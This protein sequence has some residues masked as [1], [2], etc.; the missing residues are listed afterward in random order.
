MLQVEQLET[1]LTPTMCVLTPPGEPTPSTCLVSCIHDDIADI[2]AAA[3]A[4]VT[5]GLAGADE[6]EAAI[7]AETDVEVEDFVWAEPETN[8]FIVQYQSLRDSE[9]RDK[10]LEVKARALELCQQVQT[11]QD[12]DYSGVVGWGLA[13]W[14]SAQLPWLKLKL[15]EARLQL[16]AIAQIHDSRI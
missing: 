15:R 9:L 8:P 4:A 1:R 11:I 12:H 16:Q 2:L 10:A 5:T 6:A 3:D 14:D 13:V 7:E